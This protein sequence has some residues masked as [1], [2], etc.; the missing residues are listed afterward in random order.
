MTLQILEV[1][2]KSLLLKNPLNVVCTYE[3][4]FQNPNITRLILYTHTF[5]M[6]VKVMLKQNKKTI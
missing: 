3:F 2:F 6:A 1:A 5:K 4:T